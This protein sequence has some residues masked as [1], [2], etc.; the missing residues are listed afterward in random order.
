MYTTVL[1]VAEFHEKMGQTIGDPRDPNVDIDTQ[2]RWE[3]IR[4]EFAELTLALEGKDKDGAPLT[5]QAKIVAVADALGDMCYVIAGAAVTWGIDLGEVFA[6]IHRSN[7]TKSKSAKREDGKILK[8][9]EYQPPDIQGALDRAKADIEVCGTGPDSY[10]PYPTS[11]WD[12]SCPHQDALEVDHDTAC[13][14][15]SPNR[16]GQFLSRGAFI[17]DCS[18]ERTHEISTLLGSRGG[19]AKEGSTIC[20]CGKV[21]KVIFH[22]SNGQ[23]RAEILEGS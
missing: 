12:C 19:L 15:V 6:A 16:N 3:L 5:K 8:G 17:F 10:W 22:R 21:Y 4:E 1:D 14:V 7:M 18:C 2:L 11:E 20:V 13:A 9:P 23:E